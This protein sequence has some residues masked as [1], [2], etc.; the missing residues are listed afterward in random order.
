MAKWQI[1]QKK[2]DDNVQKIMICLQ[3]GLQ[4]TSACVRAWIPRSTF[5]EWLNDD[6][7]FRTRVED[8][9]EYWLWIVETKMKEK[10]DEGYRPAIDKELKSKRRSVYWDKLDSTETLIQTTID[11]KDIKGKTPAELDEMRRKIL[12]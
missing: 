12:G 1:K 2:T 8:A 9:E 6:D 7:H 11:Y 5:Y 4:R 10:I 3:N